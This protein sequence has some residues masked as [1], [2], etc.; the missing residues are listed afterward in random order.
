MLE[1]IAI[2]TEFS[3][4]ITDDL[5]LGERLHIE[6]RSTTKVSVKEQYCVVKF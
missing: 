5:V 4:V 1:D 2:L 3:I 6:A